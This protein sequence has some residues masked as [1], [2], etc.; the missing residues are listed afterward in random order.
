MR[1]I[2]IILAVVSLTTLVAPAEVADS[3]QGGFTVKIATT[4]HAGP[5]EVYDRLVHNVGD[6][7]NSE[8]TFSNDAHNLSIDDKVTGCFCEKFPNGGGVRHG[9]VIM[10]MPNKLLVISGAIGPLQKFG[11][12]GTLTFAILPIHKDTRLEVTYVVGGYAS[13]GLE[14]WAAPVDKVLAEQMT[15]LKSYAE[16]GSPTTATATKP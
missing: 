1:R 5:E 15:R 16:T 13:G 9:E 2:L 8:H 7:W 11:T 6:W 12:T 3:G 4:I 14:T 10:I